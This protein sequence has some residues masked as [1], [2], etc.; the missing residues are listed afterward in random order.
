[1]LATLGKYVRIISSHDTSLIQKKHLLLPAWPLQ[2]MGGAVSERV[3]LHNGSKRYE[4]G[5]TETFV[6]TALDVGDLAKM[7]IGHDNTGTCYPAVIC[8]TSYGHRVLAYLP[9]YFASN[10]GRAVSKDWLYAA[11]TI[12]K[13]NSCSKALRIPHS[14]TR[15]CC[16]RPLQAP[17]PPG[18]WTT[19]RWRT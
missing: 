2:G 11:P 7:R 14:P 17:T 16:A 8:V 3:A 15:H 6:I 12:F 19:W 9:T 18:I 13:A 4:R 1:M 10:P 5:S